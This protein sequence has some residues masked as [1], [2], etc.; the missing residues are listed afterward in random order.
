MRHDQTLMQ[1]TITHYKQHLN[2]EIQNLLNQN[3]G[4]TSLIVDPTKTKLL[5]QQLFWGISST[6]AVIRSVE[7]IV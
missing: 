6:V 7:T 1:L 5:F 3:E 4:I 2:D